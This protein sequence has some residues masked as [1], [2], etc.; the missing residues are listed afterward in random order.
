MNEVFPG[1][2]IRMMTSGVA[3][4]V[5][6]REEVGTEERRPILLPADVREP[7]AGAAVWV[8]YAGAADVPPT[9]FP[10]DA[11]EIDDQRTDVNR[12][13]WLRLIGT[14][15]GDEGGLE[16]RVSS[17]V[18][19]HDLE[20]ETLV[21]LAAIYQYRETPDD[22][23]PFVIEEFW[24]V[25]PDAAAGVYYVP[26]GSGLLGSQVLG[27][28]LMIRALEMMDDPDG[29]SYEE[30]LTWEGGP[31]DQ[32]LFAFQ[33]RPPSLNIGGSFERRF[34]L[35]ND[36][37]IASLPTRVTRAMERRIYA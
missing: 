23:S 34:W 7:G 3:V 27:N 12:L 18:L 15:A 29:W 22:D 19:T 35:D 20:A 8:A 24:A 4:R 5:R 11:L 16:F 36:F 2:G 28:R 31:R 10:T 33:I 25:D 6:A 37:R 1:R 14:G 30:P 13:A 32:A 26:L 9:P 17:A 21:G